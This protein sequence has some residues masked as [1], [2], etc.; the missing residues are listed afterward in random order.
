MKTFLKL[1]LQIFNLLLYY[2]SY[3]I[4]KNKSLWVFGSWFGN[5]Y[6]DS[7]KYLFEYINAYHSNI[8]CVWLS[9]NR[10][11]ISLVR[12]LGFE[13]YHTY[14]LKGYLLSSR[15]MVSIVSTSFEDVNKYIPTKYVINTW[16]GIPLKKILYDDKINNSHID[17]RKSI[18]LRSIFPFRKILSDYS[19]IIA[20]SESEA[21]N[22]S[23]AF[24]KPINNIS[25]C[26]LP[27]NDV[28]KKYDPP[29]ERQKVIYMPTHRGE[30]KFD[31]YKLFKSELLFIN[32]KLNKLNIDLYVKLHFYHDNQNQPDNFSNIHFIRDN[33]INQ[34][35]YSIINS[36]DILITDYSSVYFDFLLSGRPI[37]FAPFDLDDY[38]SSDREMYFDYNEVTPGPKCRNWHEVM[39]WIVNFKNNPDLFALDRK[40][41]KDNFHVYQDGSSCER[42][43]KEALR[44]I[45]SCNN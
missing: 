33:D 17:T 19:V 42:V 12:K 34:D 7:P 26:G 16:H 11:T 14:S 10:S 38:L 22:L 23:S 21:I 24:N 39:E 30:G 45:G 28:F 20:S 29:K 44:L 13:A 9:N 43:Y 6:C 3:C 27:R 36:F 1:I 35:I 2:A 32:N 4:Q 15:A 31:I 5:K 41:L 37:I 8:R 18:I 25:I 40:L